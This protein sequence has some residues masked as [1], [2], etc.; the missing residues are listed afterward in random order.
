MTEVD[1]PSLQTWLQKPQTARLCPAFDFPQKNSDPS[2]VPS[3]EMKWA[4]HWPQGLT[5]ALGPEVGTGWH[6]GLTSPV[7]S[8]ATVEPPECPD[9]TVPATPSPSSLVVGMEEGGS[10]LSSASLAS[11]S[12]TLFD[13]RSKSQALTKRVPVSLYSQAVRKLRNI[14]LL[15]S[16][17]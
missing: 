16:V 4:C 5:L 12:W 1:I 14:P 11:G 10:E 17:G 15:A 3:R 8:G 13:G 2:T 9:R 6:A 7:P